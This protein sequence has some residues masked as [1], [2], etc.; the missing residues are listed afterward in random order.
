VHTS[1]FQCSACQHSFP[2]A[3]YLDADSGTVPVGCELLEEMNNAF[4][5]VRLKQTSRTVDRSYEKRLRLSYRLNMHD[6][7][8]SGYAFCLEDGV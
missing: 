5:H 6:K 2:S 8:W 3:G 4:I 7:G 1:E